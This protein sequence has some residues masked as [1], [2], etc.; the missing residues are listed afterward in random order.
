MK[1]K[2]KS[3]LLLFML[4][5]CKQ[6]ER[7]LEINSQ[8]KNLTD[9]L[10]SFLRAGNPEPGF[11]AYYAWGISGP[12]GNAVDY[13]GHA[14]FFPNSSLSGSMVDV[15]VVNFGTVQVNTDTARYGT[16]AYNF[17]MPNKLGSQNASQWGSNVSF[18][19]TGGTSY[20]PFQTKFYVPQ[21]IFLDTIPFVCN[22]SNGIN[23]PSI[24]KSNPT[25]VLNWN[26]DI[27]NK[28]VA[29]IMYYDG[30]QSNKLNSALSN[31]SF[32]N[33]FI[34]PDNGSYTI[35]PLDMLPYPVGSVLEVYVARGNDETLNNN[36]KDVYVTANTYAKRTYI[37]LQ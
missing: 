31:K 30:V 5:A 25:T 27:H 14:E 24:S 36:G 7:S 23:Y 15:G 11:I 9:R 12:S 21:V 2:F 1:T 10:T 18:G 8:P 35:K 4:A 16:Y 32:S 19:I 3:L 13:N 34:V 17:T 6:N 20:N 26:M 37:V 33:A 28:Q 22:G 29:V